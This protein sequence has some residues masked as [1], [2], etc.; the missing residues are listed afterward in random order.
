AWK[1]PYLAPFRAD[2]GGS[3]EAVGRAGTEARMPR[4]LFIFGGIMKI[5]L[6]L[7]VVIVSAGLALA[8]AVPAHAGLITGVNAL[9]G[10][11]K[12]DGTFDYT[13]V[14][15]NHGTLSITLKNTSPAANGGYLTAFV[16]NNPG[17]HITGATL[18][19]SNLHFHLLGGPTFNNGVP[20]T[21]YGQFDL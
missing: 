9:N 16:F 15:A 20:G 4:R 19:S 14:D 2:L 21:P 10:L 17:Q 13:P 11:G 6:R 7:V 1:R 8:V 18:W 12:F 3:H 5:A